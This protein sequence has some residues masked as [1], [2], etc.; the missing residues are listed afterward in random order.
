MSR[1]FRFQS[2]MGLHLYQ[3]LRFIYLSDFISPYITFSFF[4]SKIA[5]PMLND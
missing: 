1:I 3:D 2:L 4:A 5:K